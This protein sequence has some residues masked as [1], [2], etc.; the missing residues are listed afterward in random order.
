MSEAQKFVDFLDTVSESPVF[1]LT[2]KG[3]ARR[4]LYTVLVTDYN[5]V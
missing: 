1:S 3:V 5:S 4:I 2:T